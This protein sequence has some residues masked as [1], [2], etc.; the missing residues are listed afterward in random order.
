MRRLWL[1][2]AIF[3][4]FHLVEAKAQTVS[5]YKSGA[6]EAGAI[7]KNTG[8]ALYGFYCTAIAGATAGTC[9]IMD[10][11]TVPSTGAV[12]PID[13][14]AFTSA[15]G[16][17]IYRVIPFRTTNGVVVILSSATTPFTYTTGTATGYLGVDWQ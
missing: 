11:A 12:T 15:A 1:A 5:H 6:L 3:L 13:S 7:A 10:S 8:G 4:S 9:S 17:S 14:C 16:C 2:L